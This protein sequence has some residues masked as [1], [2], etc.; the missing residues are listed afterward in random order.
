MSSLVSY[1][2]VGSSMSWLFEY[3][4]FYML[5]IWV[6]GLQTNYFLPSV[7][8]TFINNYINSL[9]SLIVQGYTC[10]DYSYTE[11]RVLWT[12]VTTSYSA[13]RCRMVMFIGCVE[14]A[15]AV[16]TLKAMAGPNSILCISIT[17]SDH[18]LQHLAGSAS[19]LC[20]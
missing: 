17:S 13:L 8:P 6:W 20:K 3:A 16:A 9:Q 18:N 19:Q 1:L 14:S 4:V 7:L 10:V 15:R 5:V 2:G 12:F 11:A